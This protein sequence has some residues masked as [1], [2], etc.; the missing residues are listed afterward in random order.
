MTE[1]RL[2]DALKVTESPQPNKPNDHKLVKQLAFGA[3]GVAAIAS[4][5]A[6]IVSTQQADTDKNKDSDTSDTIKEKYEDVFKSVSKD[7]QKQVESADKAVQKLVEDELNGKKDVHDANIKSAEDAIVGIK[8]DDND[9][10]SVRDAYTNIVNVVKSPTID[11]LQNMR[12]SIANMSDSNISRHL[13]DTF[14]SDMI[15]HVAEKTNKTVND[16]TSASKPLTPQQ[17]KAKEVESKKKSDAAQKAK[18]DA[19]KAKADK[20]AAEKAKAD[21]AAAEAAKQATAAAEAAKQAAAAEAQRQA[22]AA[23]AQQASNQQAYAEAPQQNYEAPSNGGGYTPPAQNN[24]GSNYTPP[25]AAQPSNPA[26]TQ[27][28]NGAGSAWTPSNSNGA[29]VSDSPGG[30]DTDWEWQN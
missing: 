20:A 2:S 11:N 27:P 23:A 14:E 15:K 5:G 22:E 24:G 8:G 6:G 4:I 28:S 29:A 25:A 17:V 7:K 16:V 3:I 10:K 12:T 13:N 26:P 21:A 30:W 18:A 1:K 9:L 19:E